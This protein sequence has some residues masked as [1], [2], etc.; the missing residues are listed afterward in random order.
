LI[1]LKRGDYLIASTSTQD[2]NIV[3][4]GKVKFLIKNIL[5]KDQIK[6][7]HDLELWY[8]TIFSLLSLTCSLLIVFAVTGRPEE[9]VLESKKENDYGGMPSDEDEDYEDE[10]G[11]ENDIKVDSMGNTIE[12][13]EDENEEQ[14]EES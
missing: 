6:H 1:W 14:G 12:N 5:N 4:S 3:D 11:E 9:F 2:P 8:W 7:L 13:Q 10:D